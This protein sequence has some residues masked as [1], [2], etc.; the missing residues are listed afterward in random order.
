MTST[1]LLPVLPT[2]IKAAVLSHADQATLA[3]ACRSSLAL[4]QLAGPLLYHSPDIASIEALELFFC[5]TVSRTSLMYELQT[6]TCP[7]SPV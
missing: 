2:E 4:L 5:S 6:L 3:A 7:S 1:A